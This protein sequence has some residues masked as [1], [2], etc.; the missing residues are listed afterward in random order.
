MQADTVAQAGVGLG[1]IDDDVASAHQRVDGGHD[2]L[3]AEVEL[4]GGFLVL[5]VGQFAFQLLVEGGL[6]GHHAASHRIGHTP[7]G[8][9]FRVSFA[10]LGMIGQAEVVVDAPAEHLLAVEAHVGTQFAFKLRE[11]EI[12]VYL[13]TVLPD[14]ATG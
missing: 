8:G 13:F 12:A 6:A 7:A 3:I 9:T 10:D 1:V 2:A 5:E 11:C 4:E 14:R